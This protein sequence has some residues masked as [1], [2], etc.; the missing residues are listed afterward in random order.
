MKVAL[1][2]VDSK[3]PNLA[4]MKLS[5]YFKKCYKSEKPK[6]KLYSKP[7]HRRL[8]K[9]PRKEKLDNDTDIILASKVFQDS[10]IPDIGEDFQKNMVIGGVGSNNDN[11]FH[12]NLDSIDDDI[13]FCLPEIKHIDNIMPDYSLYN[14]DYSMGFTTRGCMR[15]CKFCFV[16]KHEG[17]LHIVSDNIK[18]FWN[19]KHHK[20]VLLDNNIL[21]LPKHFM[22]ITN[23][24]IENELE[25]DFNQGL[26]HR[27]LNDFI[28]K[29]LKKLKTPD[30]L[31]FAF[32]NFN[33][34]ST[35][36]KAINLLQ[37]HGIKESFWYV[38]CGFNTTI[39]QDLERVNFLREHNQIAYVQK[40]NGRTDST[41][42]NVFASWVNQRKFYRKMTFREYLKKGLTEYDRKGFLIPLKEVYDETL[43]ELLND[44]KIG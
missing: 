44:R 26:D 11:D 30:R 13:S 17:K 7:W 5:S 24:I 25:V 12:R 35:V 19:K 10:H 21:A 14:S 23:Q 34:F 28:L 32:D 16:P 22:K 38:L 2:D 33:S 29:Q 18:D 1:I 41:S 37:K 6:I 27:L 15:K 36:E 8:P 39:H 42:L 9:K 43:E 40:Y 4:L 31:R 20:L 3:I